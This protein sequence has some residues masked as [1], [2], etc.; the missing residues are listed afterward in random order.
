MLHAVSITALYAALNALLNVALALQ[1]IRLRLTE[2][3]SLGTG[4]SKKLLNA[5]RMH[6][7]NSEYVPLA[8]IMLLVCELCGGKS[9]PLHV[10]GGSL[11]VGRIM[12]VIGI[13]RRPPNIFRAGG[14]TLTLLVILAASG[15]A[16]MLR[17]ES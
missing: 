4:E 6:G 8:L 13:P 15:Y 10:F 3:V 2:R 7:N 12:H 11:F 5:V 9:V 14:V 17:S 16:L 1:I